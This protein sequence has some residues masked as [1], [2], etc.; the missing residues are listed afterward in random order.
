M[1]TYQ[2]VSDEACAFHLLK[3]DAIFS[4]IPVERQSALVCQAIEIGKRCSRKFRGANLTRFLDE[5]GVK[6]IYQPSSPITGLHAQIQYDEKI[7]KIELYSPVIE[8]M[9]QI[10]QTIVEKLTYDQVS[11]LFIAHEFYHWVEYSSHSLTQNKCDSVEVTYLGFIHTDRKVRMTS[12]IAAF[13]FAKEQLQLTIHPLIYDQLMKVTGQA[14]TSSDY[15][16]D[17]WLKEYSEI[18]LRKDDTKHG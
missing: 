13:Q 17:Q 3:Q 11:Q 12:E 4:R 7:K 15:W 2:S 5:D 14:G 10:S 16:P 6:I 1:L 9:M 8:Q 18:L